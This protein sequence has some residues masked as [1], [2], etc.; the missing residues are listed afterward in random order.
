MHRHP[1]A[2]ITPLAKKLNPPSE[3]N[4]AIPSIKRKRVTFEASGNPFESATANS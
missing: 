1:L 4:S 3:S 2:T